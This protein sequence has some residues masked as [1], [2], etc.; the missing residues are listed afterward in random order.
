MLFRSI[1]PVS[2]RSSQATVTQPHSPLRK[3]YS[4]QV[5]LVADVEHDRL[6]NEQ[7]AQE[8]EKKRKKSLDRWLKD[9]VKKEQQYRKKLEDEASA[10]GFTR[11]EGQL[12]TLVDDYMKKR[13]VG[14]GCHKYLQ[15]LTLPVG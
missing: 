8:D 5:R 6:E 3:T 4:S 7:K 14:S 10:G 1:E 11:T 2:K 12:N 9:S 13:E 15:R